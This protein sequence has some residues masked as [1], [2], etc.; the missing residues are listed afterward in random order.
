MD[1]AD[2]CALAG[3]DVLTWPYWNGSCQNTSAKLSSSPT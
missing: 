3:A 1:V 2:C